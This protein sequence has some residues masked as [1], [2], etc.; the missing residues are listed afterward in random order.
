MLSVLAAVLGRL[1][2]WKTICWLQDVFPDIAMRAGLLPEGVLT[3]LLQVAARWSL[4]MSDRVIV[5]GRCME[6][7]LLAVGLQPHRVVLISNWADGDQLAPVAAEENWF[8]KQ[9]DLEGKLVIMYSGNLGVVHETESL[10]PVVRRLSATPEMCVLFV[11]E[12]QGKSRL[13]DWVCRERLENVT[14]V[15]YQANEHLRYSLSAGDIHLVTL[16]T[17]MEGLS[18][19]SK[20]YGIMAVG[21]P[22]VF[23]GPERSEVAA[24]GRDAGCGEVFAPGEGGKAA[25]TILGLARDLHP[26]ERLGLAGARDFVHVLAKP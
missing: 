19:P 14:F 16:R 21:R 3:G 18:V 9:Q 24:L 1:K 5:V 13:E 4:R 17:E 12:G 20:V 8:R 11:G 7:R 10:I 26:R 22:V 23:I 6:R 25:Q 15:G 2:R